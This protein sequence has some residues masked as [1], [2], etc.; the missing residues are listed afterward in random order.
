MLSVDLRFS[1]FNLKVRN[2]VYHSKALVK[3][4]LYVTG[5]NCMYSFIHP[6]QQS[7]IKTMPACLD[8]FFPNVGVMRLRLSF[9][10]P[11]YS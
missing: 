2:Y 11:H 9:S 7:F 1:S 8:L 5:H 10:M 3:F 6:T 4:A